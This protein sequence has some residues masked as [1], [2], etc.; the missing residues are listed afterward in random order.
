[1]PPSAKVP[2][3]VPTRVWSTAKSVRAR[4][5]SK[6]LVTTRRSVP[7]L[8]SARSPCSNQAQCSLQA[9]SP[10]RSTLRARRTMEQPSATSNRNP[11]EDAPMELVA[12]KKLYLVAGRSSRYLAEEIAAELNEPLGE[13]NLA[14][15]ANGEIHCRFNESVRGTDVFIIQTHAAI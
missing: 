4:A 6:P 9:R 3:S 12:S 8:W 2:R 5:S 7:A 13:P 1:A 14:E 10:G 11:S 15:F